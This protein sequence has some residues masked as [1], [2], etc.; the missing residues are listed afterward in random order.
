LWRSTI[1]T[2]YDS[3]RGGWCSKVTAPFGVGV[4]KH[5]RRGWKVFSRFVRYE[6][7]DGSKVRFWHEW[8]ENQLLKISFPDMFSIARCKDA[9]VA[10]HM[11]FR[12]NNLQW[13]I[14]FIRLM[15]GWKVGLIS[16]FFEL[17]YSLRTR[18]EGE[19]RICW[20]P[21]KRRQFKVKSYYHV[22]SLLSLLFL[23]R[24]FRKLKLF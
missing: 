4:W 22:L 1:E 3:L 21:S 7:R 15:H 19:D 24:V 9:W 16:S 6:V 17:L 23:G 14:F 2:K 18:Q 10:N 5:I 11:Q 12:N 13:N 20:I 8:R